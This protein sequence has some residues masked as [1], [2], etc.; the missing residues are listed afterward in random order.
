[1]LPFDTRDAFFFGLPPVFFRCYRGLLPLPIAPPFLLLVVGGKRVRQLSFSYLWASGCF[2]FFEFFRR[3][4][5]LAP[6][7]LQLTKALMRGLPPWFP[8]FSLVQ[9]RLR[10]SDLWTV[11]CFQTALPSCFDFFSLWIP[12]VSGEPGPPRT[13]TADTR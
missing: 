9:E 6:P 5:V 4:T 10:P 8:S 1:M 12:H 11:S 13:R 7:P 3:W 2:F